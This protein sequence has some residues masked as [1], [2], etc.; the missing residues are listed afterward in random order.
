MNNTFEGFL[1]RIAPK[2]GPQA[3]FDLGRDAQFNAI[4]KLIIKKGLISRLELDYELEQ[5]FS[6][7]ADQIEKMPSI[8]K[9]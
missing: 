4:T 9:S 2:V 1:T 8:P 6:K 3:S 7:I 5:E